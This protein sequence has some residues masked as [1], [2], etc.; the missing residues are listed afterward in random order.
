MGNEPFTM[1]VAEDFISRLDYGDAARTKQ[2][3]T[4][5]TSGGRPSKKR[6]ARR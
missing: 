3:S 6:S 2:V 4:Y 1:E 5:C